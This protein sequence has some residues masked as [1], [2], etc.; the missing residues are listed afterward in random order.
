MYIREKDIHWAY[1]PFNGDKDDNP[2]TDPVETFGVLDVTYQKLQN[3]FI[4]EALFQD[5]R[6]NKVTNQQ[7]QLFLS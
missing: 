7:K 3:T 6:S 1:W 4:L 2:K 5:G